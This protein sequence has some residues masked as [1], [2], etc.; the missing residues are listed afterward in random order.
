MFKNCTVK[1]G[2]DMFGEKNICVKIIYTDSH[3]E[4]HIPIDNENTDYQKVL[5]WVEEGNTIEDAD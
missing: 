2:K 1:Y 4:L 3:R 5:E